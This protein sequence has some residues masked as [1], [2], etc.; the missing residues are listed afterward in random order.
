V[1][2]LDGDGVETRA[3]SE[4]VFFDLDGRALAESVGWVGADD[5]RRAAKFPVPG[6]GVTTANDRAMPLAA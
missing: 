4:G 1:L 2:D 6:R 5:G 3:R